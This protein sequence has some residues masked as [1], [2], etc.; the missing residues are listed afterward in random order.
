[1]AV[2]FERQGESVEFSKLLLEHLDLIHV[3]TK[4][5]ADDLGELLAETLRK[6]QQWSQL[7][8]TRLKV[9][10]DSIVRYSETPG[11]S[12]QLSPDLTLWAERSWPMWRDI[13]TAIDKEMESPTHDTE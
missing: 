3:K 12:A 6:S 10:E 13:F 1:M 4:I 5:S 7:R 11:K 2:I 9:L 8:A